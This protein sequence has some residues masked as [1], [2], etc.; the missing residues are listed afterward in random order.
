M[1]KNLKV[2]AGLLGLAG[3]ALLASGCGKNNDAPPPAPPQPGP[4]VQG[5]VTGPA[6]A[7]VPITGQIP[8][9]ATNIYF[10]WVNIVGG[11]V[12]GNPQ[13]QGTVIVG[14]SAT[15]GPFQRQSQS[16]GFISMS[17]TPNA[18]A[19]QSPQGTPFGGGMQAP[20]TANATGFIQ[21]SQLVQNDI[22]AT[23]GGGAGIGYP[24]GMPMGQPG[25]Q[26][27]MP[28]PGMPQGTT[29][30]NI[31][32]SGIALDLGH[33]DYLIHSGTVYLYLNNS[34]H[35]YKMFF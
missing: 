14:G 23:F 18:P 21:M 33:K 16:D 8:F 27:G 5:P 4:P 2:R 12:P 10:S 20:T 9:I 34:Q 35:G 17:I 11:Q 25:M 22:Y 1:K 3:I 15:G 29:P 7:C 24:G 26:P 31:C 19:Q 6:S 28:Q 32:V 13:A 30:Q